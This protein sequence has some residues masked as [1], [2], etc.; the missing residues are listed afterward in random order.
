PDGFR[1]EFVSVALVRGHRDRLLAGLDP[2]QRRLA[3][4]LVGAHH[5]R[6]RPFVPYIAEQPG[7]EDVRLVWAGQ[8]A[9]ASPDHRLWRL[10][11]G[12]TDAFWQLVRRHGY[13][14]L[15]YLEALLRL[16]DAAQ[17]A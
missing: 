6:G 11:A 12:W 15:A 2:D 1:H 17:S 14:G 16:A 3:E 5:G 4:W 13:W 8:G 7:A 10:D 9:S